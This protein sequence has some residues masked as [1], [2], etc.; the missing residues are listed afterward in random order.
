MANIVYRGARV[1]TVVNSLPAATGSTDQGAKNSPLTNDEI[2][3]N[4]YALEIGKLDKN[5]AASQTVAGPVQFTSAV[6]IN[7]NLVVNGT[8]TT[9]NSTTLSVDD[10]NIELG[11]ITTP[12]NVTA[13]GGGITL[14][15]ATD[16]TFNWLNATTAWTSSE[17]IDLANTKAYYI[18]GTS[19]LSSTTL[20]SG[21]TGSSLTSVG[22]LATGVWQAS[23]IA[24]NY[25]GTGVNNGGRTITI[26]GNFA[27]VGAFATTLTA[28]AATTLTLPTTGTLA[29]LA[30]A[31]TLT[32]K[33]ITGTFTG[34]LTGNVT[35]NAT[36]ATTLATARN[37]NGVSFNGSADITITANTTNVLTIGTGL[38][39]SSFN[40]SGA[41]TIA[42]DSTVVTLTGTQTLTNKTLTLPTIGGTGATFSGATSGTTVLKAAAVAGTT[43]IT[44]PG[45][46]GT[47]ALTSDLPTVSD[48]TL[49]IANPSAGATNT[50]VTLNLS[51]TYSANTAN[52]RTINAVVG[53]A[54]TA[55]TGTMTGAAVGFLKKSAEDTYVLDNNTYALA[56]A[57][58]TVNDG[59]FA[60]SI[61]STAGAT[62]TTVTWG[63]SS[64]FSANTA[65]AAT[66]DLRVGPALTNLAAIMTTA[67]AGFI[68]RGATADTYSIDTNTYLTGN[69]SIT[70]SGDV[71]GT[72][73]TAITTT[74]ANNAVTTVKILDSNVTNAKL[75]NSTISGVALGQNLNT[76]TMAVAGVGLTGAATYNGSGA[77]A[78]TVT[79]NATNANTASTIVARDASGNFTAGTITAAL[80]GNATTAT[81]LATGRT[82]GM[83]GDVTWTSA[84]FNG[85]A[86]V[87]GTSTLATVGTAGTYSSVTVDAKGR[88]TSGSNPGYIT[89]SLG[90]SALTWTLT[91]PLVANTSYVTNG[92][93]YNSF[94]PGSDNSHGEMIQIRS[95]SGSNSIAAM[96]LGHY[97]GVGRIEFGNFSYGTSVA[98]PYTSSTYGNGTYPIVMRSTAA[99]GT[100]ATLE[101][102]SGD[103]RAPIFY[104]YNNTSYYADLAN[105]NISL[106]LA[107]AISANR[108]ITIYGDYTNASILNIYGTTNDRVLTL[109]PGTGTTYA[110]IQMGPSSGDI[111]GYKFWVGSSTLLT[112][113]SNGNLTAS[114]NVTAY[115]DAR[116]KTNVQTI[117]NSLDKTLKLR[118][119][120]YERDGKKN[121]GVIAQEIR[122][123]L[124]EVVHEADDEQKTLSVSYGNVVGLLIE[125]IKELNAKV[126]DLQNQLANK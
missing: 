115:S 59:A 86:N 94:A 11:D 56:S 1:P 71:T 42:I 10:K 58:P 97:Q 2:D 92:L 26:A 62:N 57:I 98:N 4:L 34:P 90:T 30:G 96:K 88:V 73:T 18:N 23:T 122:E 108:N 45:T 38:S 125:A 35:G 95:V 17:H 105:T 7:G 87:T 119:V 31:E 124:P 74:I 110:D 117:E 89:S 39:G 116:L 24:S 120:S 41:V 6:T 85:S 104:E 76:L 14:K 113:A 66:Y 102:T 69:Q 99:S 79:S 20:G 53:P 49:T 55:L 82:I 19:V 109:N 123:I 65:N 101:V 118:G 48:G 22:T 5:D 15:G 21:V 77:S 91:G 111:L 106:S 27:T 52:N 93:Q 50:A 44:M 78:F 8:T 33:T 36:T 126:E 64:G 37:I 83:T 107:G 9:V 13:D 67:G 60:V 80:S 68:K 103:I 29:T 112:I 75:A 47:M 25:G 70:L 72:G 40:G 121:I 32:N 114:G 100:S 63:T 61:S 81:T 28:T 43:T 84:S 46:T 16:K 54:L 51:G 3:K 12:T